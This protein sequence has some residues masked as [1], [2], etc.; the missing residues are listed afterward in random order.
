MAEPIYRPG[1]IDLRCPCCEAEFTASTDEPISCPECEAPLELY[2]TETEA[3]ERIAEFE[4]TKAPGPG[5]YW[6]VA[7]C[8]G[9]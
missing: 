6:I 8:A 7:F 3:D 4:G 9:D 2:G 5:A 1:S